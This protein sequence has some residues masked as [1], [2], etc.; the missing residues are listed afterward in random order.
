MKSLVPLKG[1]YAF[2]AVAET[3]S[4]TK[5][6]EVLNV[7]HSA[8]SQAIKSLETL[9]GLSLFERV[10]RQVTLNNQGNIY[11]KKVAPALEQIVDATAALQSAEHE[12]RITLNMVNSLAIH[13]WV[14]RMQAFQHHA[15]NLDVRVSNLIGHFQ[16]ERE[17]VDVALIHGTK[18]EWRDYHC[19]KLGDDELVMVCHPDLVEDKA[20]VSQLVERYPA[21]FA[22]NDRR[23]GDWEH[24]CE[25]NQITLPKRQKNLGFI[26]SVHAVQA[27][28]RK[29]GV[30][31]THRQFVKDDIKHGMLVEVGESVKHPKQSFYF[32]CLPEKLRSESVMALRSWLQSEFS[33]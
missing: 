16:L 27:A 17:N 11:Y 10:G 2:V 29:L 14:P 31:V 6:A 22:T 23:Q 20:S 8:V 13:W 28:A 12:N 7:S 3:G 9:L 21:I 26:A 15:P 1:I 30:F 19:E 33:S 25:A 18:E 24:W 4:M 5:A 32:A